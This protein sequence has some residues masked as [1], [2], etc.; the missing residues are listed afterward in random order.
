MQFISYNIQV[1]GVEICLKKS[2]RCNLHA[3]CDP[4]EG[5]DTAE[6]ELDCADEYRKNKLIEKQATFRCQSPHH[7]D[8]SVRNNRS[9]GVVWIRAALNDDNVE[10][11]KGEDEEEMSTVWVT[12]GFPGL[13]P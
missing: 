2:Q 3:E 8:D 11:W 9:L 5:S 13:E 1:G 12:H 7:N 10:C 6:D 4:A